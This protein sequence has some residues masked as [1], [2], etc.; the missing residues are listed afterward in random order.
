M[1]AR[2][3]RKKPPKAGDRVTAS[4]GRRKKTRFAELEIIKVTEWFPE[5][6]N[7]NDYYKF[8]GYGP[9][10]IA[11]ME[12]FTSFSD[13]MDAYIALNQH[14]DFNDPKRRHYFIEFKMVK[15]L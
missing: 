2:Y 10:K 8:V 11:E 7:I 9:Q 13:F 15:V 3:W 1:T 5:K 12:G 14:H 4:T 6:W